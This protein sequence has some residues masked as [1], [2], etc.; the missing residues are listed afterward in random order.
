[1]STGLEAASAIG[2]GVGGAALVSAIVL[3]LVTPQEKESALVVAPVPMVGG[4]GAL[5]GGRF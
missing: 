5:L 3:Y 4:A 2:F 1:V